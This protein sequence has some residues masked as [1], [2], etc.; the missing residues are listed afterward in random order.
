MPRVCFCLPLIQLSNLHHTAL[1]ECTYT[2]YILCICWFND[3]NL[4]NSILPAYAQHEHRRR[5]YQCCSCSSAEPVH[6]GL[7]PQW[8]YP[9]NK[10]SICWEFAGPIPNNNTGWTP[11][12][13]AAAV[14]AGG[15]GKLHICW[16]LIKMLTALQLL[17]LLRMTTTVCAP[18]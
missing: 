17:P 14:A 1:H 9:H 5:L 8:A 7:P 12:R 11:A 16:A 13:Q 15:R 2:H 18:P 6:S 10:P 4:D 3:S